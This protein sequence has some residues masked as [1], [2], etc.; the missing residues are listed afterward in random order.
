MNINWTLVET[1]LLER[2]KYLEVC[3]SHQNRQRIRFF[4]TL[5]RRFI[6][7]VMMIIKYQMFRTRMIST[8]RLT[9]DS[10]KPIKLLNHSRKRRSLLLLFLLFFQSMQMFIYLDDSILWVNKVDIGYDRHPNNR[11]YIHINK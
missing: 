9:V 5:W 4:F 1:E 11:I 3:W 2:C 10:G 6:I 7:F 8:S